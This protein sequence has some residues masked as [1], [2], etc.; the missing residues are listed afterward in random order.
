MPESHDHLHLQA[1]AAVDL[2]PADWAAFRAEAHAALDVAIDYIADIRDRPIWQPMPPAARQALRAALPEQGE[3]VGAAVAEF[4]RSVL[5]YATG[6]VHPRFMG[7]VHGGGNTAG[8]AATR[9]DW[10]ARCW[11]PR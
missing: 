7:W 4:A 8:L 9:Q 1:E 2:D 11:P 6:N 10:W 5:P 3:G